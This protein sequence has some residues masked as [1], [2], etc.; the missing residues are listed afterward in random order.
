MKKII[1]M[2]HDVYKNDTSESGFQNIEAKKYKITVEEFEKHVSRIAKLIENSK[3]AKEQVEFSF[4]DGGVSAISLIAPVLEKYGFK[5]I[6]F[7]T[8]S[9]INTDGFL[10]KEQIK[11]LHNRGHIVGNHSHTH[12]TNIA[13]LPE[14]ILI[15]EW[16]SSNKILATIIS[17]EITRASIPGGSYSDTIFKVMANTGHKI[18]YTSIP[19][20]NIKCKYDAYIY[21]RM[22]VTS[23]T[24]VDQLEGLLLN[25]KKRLKLKIRWLVFDIAKR[26]LGKYYFPLRKSISNLISK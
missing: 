24:S 6:F 25:N 9:L 5:G 13:H 18:I 10:N 26:L 2:Y 8:T 16:T 19:T 3:V 21:G 20:T 4:D 1:L 22:S 12:P 23:N 11:E 14:D 17:D 15:E 7:I